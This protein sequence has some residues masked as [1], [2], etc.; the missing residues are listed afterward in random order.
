MIITLFSGGTGSEEIQ[1]GLWNFIGKYIK[2]NIIVNGYDDGK[3]TGI[4][5]KIYND[6][7]LGPSDL[8][9]N[10]LLRHKLRYGETE[11]YKFLNHRF[12]SYN[13]EEYINNY[14]LSL[15]KV[16]SNLVNIEIKKEDILFF[17]N[18]INEFFKNPESLNFK[19]EDFNIGNIIYAY[20][21]NKIGVNETI[22]KINQIL[23]I[24]NEV[25]YQSNYPHRLIAITEK[26]Q[27]LDTEEKI[28]NFSNYDDKIKDIALL[29]LNNKDDEPIIEPNVET[30]I[31]ES[32]I[33][34]FSCGT[35]WSSLIPT[36]KSH[37]FYNLIKKCKAKKYLISNLFN[38]KDMINWKPEE[39]INLYSKYLPLEDIKII[40]PNNLSDYEFLFNY[41]YLILNNIINNNKHN[42]LELIKNIFVD[43]FREYL[44]YSNIIF[45]YD[46][47]IYDKD[48]LEI[49]N[50]IINEI[51]VLSNKKNTYLLSGN[52]KKNIIFDN[53]KINRDIITNQGTYLYNDS[54]FIDNKY[55]LSDNDV[56]YLLSQNI[57]NQYI[58][59][60]LV[61][62]CIRNLENR[63]IIINNLN[64]DSEFKV[65]KT[66]KKSIELMKK[67]VSKIIGFNYIV[68]KY[69]L[70]YKNDLLYI[71]D[72]DDVIDTDIDT[73]NK[74]NKFIIKNQYELYA[75]LKVLNSDKKIKNDLLIVAGGVNKRMNLD[76]PKL[77]MKI[78][79]KTILDN[80]IEKARP[81]VNEI[82]LL[83]N[84]KYYN[85]FEENGY[86][87]IVKCYGE[88][89]FIPNGNLET[90]IY[91]IN[92]LS[93]KISN[94]VIIIWGDCVIPDGNIFME[95]SFA[96]SDFLISS[97]YEKEPYAYIIPKNK[98][99]M[100]VQ[101]IKFLKN[102]YVDYGIHDMSLFV[103]NINLL[104]SLYKK[105]YSTIYL[106]N[107]N[108]EKHLFDMIKIINENKNQVNYY[109]TDYPTYSFNTQEELKE[110]IDKRIL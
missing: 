49:S 94:N 33:I 4:V 105:K 29:D 19:Y 59:N 57:V 14:L 91:G 69:D 1:K 88:S 55:L 70:K 47:T 18:C 84:D 76:Y 8:R 30:I 44:K 6:K 79:D 68:N 34:I 108:K 58:E 61:S 27:I 16:D 25:Y 96:N 67:N 43:Y 107:K 53:L 46:Y 35:Q 64:L 26:N 98:S 21:F 38:D 9:K 10:Q 74:I 28:V 60:R 110:L 2:V 72:E 48:N 85:L 83:T 17:Y 65:I 82:Y 86:Q 104:Y 63:D 45:D 31:N 89:E 100:I 3:S 102:E 20:L 50:L 41:Q 15:E 62:L 109:L 54:K 103:I 71:S 24:P 11:L 5:R 80:I 56:N 101:E 39:Y 93:K 36:Y 77:L 52:D 75:Y 78:D 37:N 7:I 23:K 90:I 95:N 13:P 66:G 92:K 51:H 42:G 87:N 32:D 40:Y 12:T 97:K 81:H 73:N 106:N 22:N 99:R